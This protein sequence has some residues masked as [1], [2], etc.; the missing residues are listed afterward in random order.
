MVCSVVLVVLVV[1]TV[2]TVGT[3]TGVVLPREPCPVARSSS[4]LYRELK[5]GILATNDRE[6]TTDTCKYIQNDRINFDEIWC[7]VF[8]L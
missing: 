5:R 2:G 3:Y 8:I 4:L 7:E 6:V 1:L